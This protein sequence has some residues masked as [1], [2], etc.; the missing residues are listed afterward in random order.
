MFCVV[1]VIILYTLQSAVSGV[2]I[3]HLI[4]GYDADAVHVAIRN[5]PEGSGDIGELVTA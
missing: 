4:T 1:P 3:F 2:L 5:C